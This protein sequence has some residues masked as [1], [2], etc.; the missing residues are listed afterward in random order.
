MKEPYT[1]AQD[2]DVHNLHDPQNALSL[3]QNVSERFKFIVV[4]IRRRRRNPYPKKTE[5]RNVT[6]TLKLGSVMCNVVF[7]EQVACF[8]SAESEWNE[9]F[10]QR[11]CG[12]F[13]FS[14]CAV[15]SGV[16]VYPFKEGYDE[17]FNS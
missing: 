11:S 5:L 10:F 2:D 1:N 17:H 15:F 6:R 14:Y 9:F 12:Y 4:G 7:V 3:F 16:P 8:I 13:S